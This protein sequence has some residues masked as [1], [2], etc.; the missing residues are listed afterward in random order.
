M[1]LMSEPLVLIIEDDEP[2]LRAVKNY[3]LELI[4]EVALKHANSLTG[5]I[6]ILSLNEVTFAIVDM[7]LPTYDAAKDHTGG[8]Q[9][10]G[11]GGMDILRFIETESPATYSI[12]LTQYEEFVSDSGELKDLDALRKDLQEKFSSSLLEVVYYSGLL[13]DWRASIKKAITASGII[14]K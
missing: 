3:L 7:S 1:T 13:G 5:A 4:P 2:K 11:F 6:Q 9:P 8:G 12:V 14:I 10:Q